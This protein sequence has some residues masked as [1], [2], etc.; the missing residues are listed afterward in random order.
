MSP[1]VYLYMVLAGAVATVL[2]V[3]PF[4]YLSIRLGIMDLPRPGR[5]HAQA[6]PLLGGP[7]IFLAMALTIGGHFLVGQ[8][9]ARTQFLARWLDP[10]TI[11][12][13]LRASGALPRLGTIALGALAMLAI[14]LADDVRSVPIW[15]RLGAEFVAAGLVVGLGVRPELYILPRW[16]VFVVA[17]V[18]IVGIANAFNLI[19]SMDGLAAGVAAVAAS[20]LALWAAL[21]GQPMVA[22]MLAGFVGV[23]AGFLVFNSSPA[24]IFLGSAGSLLIG[25]FLAVSVLVST[26]MV[27]RGGGLL[28]VVMPLLILGVPLYDTCSV[29]AIRLWRRRSPFKPDLNHLAHRIHRLGLSRRGTVLFIYL[30]TF[31]VGIGAVVLARDEA[32][33][34]WLKS[35]A[36][37]VQVLAIF[38]V[39]VILERVSFGGGNVNLAAPVPGELVLRLGRLTTCS[40]EIRQLSLA[41]AT[42]AVPQMVARDVTELLETRAGGRLTI[43]F[44][45]PFRE[46]AGGVALRSVE[47]DAAG[48]WVLSLA[49][50]GLDGEARKHLEFALVHHRALGDG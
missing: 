2:L 41:G 26:F 3:P 28:P 29:V 42:L 38:G 22:V 37:L 34:P 32:I 24:G 36:V 39:L 49:F 19:D 9:L 40:G 21:S 7:A 8:M 17:V 11:A 20:L 13:M 15:L 45:A 35:A 16:A 14:G 18:W 30:L 5:I 48:S 31:A 25:Y 33:A 6:T 1:F 47:R 50:D 10:E 43:R 23:L 4:K 44:E 12:A 27:G 46:V